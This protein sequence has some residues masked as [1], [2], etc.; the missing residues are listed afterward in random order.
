[1]VILN[2]Y[3]LNKKY[4]R[5]KLH[6]HDYIEYIA[7]YLVKIASST[8]TCVP[9]RV[10]N[11]SNLERLTERH[12]PKCIPLRNGKLQGIVCRACNFTRSQMAAMGH[13]PQNLPHK[14]TIYWC[15]ECETPL[16][17]TPCFEF[18]HTVTDFRR[19]CL[20]HRLP[21]DTHE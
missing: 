20:L 12:F 14:T 16:C 21:S 3:L 18:Y 15:E 10:F 17:I 13:P 19:M 2:S 1:M 6:K 7:N 8:L 4:G 9:R 11:P 5:K